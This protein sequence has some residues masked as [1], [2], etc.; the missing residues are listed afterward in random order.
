MFFLYNINAWINYFLIIQIRA[1]EKWQ[2]LQ[3]QIAKEEQEKREQEMK[4]IEKLEMMRVAILKKKEED[5]KKRE[6]Q[7]RKQEQLQKEINDYIDNGTK[8]PDVLHEFVDNQPTK[9]LCPF[10]TKTGACRLV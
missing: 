4:I 6:E 8:T 3:E 1:Q 9:E 2:V 5:R 7:L 10:F